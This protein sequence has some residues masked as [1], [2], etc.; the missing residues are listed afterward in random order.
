MTNFACIISVSSI[1]YM[2]LQEPSLAQLFLQFIK[3]GSTAFGGNVALVAAV[4]QD[5]CEQKK[6]LSDNVLLDA[7][8]LGN[9]LPGPLA[10][11]VVAAC[12]FRMRGL[13]GALVCM[14]GVLLPAFVFICILSALYFRYGQMETLSVVLSGL[15]PAIAAIIT[16]TAWQLMQKNATRWQQRLLVLVAATVLLLSRSFLTTLLIIAA[17][18]LIGAW[19]FGNSA[20]TPSPASRQISKSPFVYAGILLVIGLMISLLP[21]SGFA[22]EV[23]QIALVFG[24]MSI[25]LFGGGYVFVPVIHDVVVSDMHWVSD[26]AFFD[27]IALGQVTPGPIMISAAFI[28]W[29][30]G[31]LWGAVAGTLGIFLPPSAL[32]LMATQFTDQLRNNKIVE[33]VFQGVR[34]AVIGMI[35][36]SVVVMLSNT[37]LNWQT[38]VIFLTVLIL[39]AWKKISQSLLVPL[40]GL[41]GWILHLVAG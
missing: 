4:R 40:A 1:V 7:T 13:I 38:G 27:G 17:S 2:R 30:V 11:N 23:K 29:K 37:A 25:T 8:T 24:S 22:A 21:L 26:Q 39:S 19:A 15:I 5:L 6:W 14:T 31:G 32:M 33:A 10:V 36:A 3:I 20:K 35:A 16:V 34:P 12:G 18:G 28:G 9:L 41:L